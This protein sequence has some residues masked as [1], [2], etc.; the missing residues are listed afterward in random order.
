M[1]AV[2]SEM[3]NADHEDDDVRVGCWPGVRGLAGWLLWKS[4]LLLR[5]L[6]LLLLLLITRPFRLL[7]LF[8]Y[9]CTF[10]WVGFSV[11]FSSFFSC[12]LGYGVNGMALGLAVW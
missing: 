12:W 1:G 8:L 6:L 10:V 11:F 4:W 2:E 3:G 5:R 7:S 9:F